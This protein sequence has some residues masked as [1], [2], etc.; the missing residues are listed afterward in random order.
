MSVRKV[1]RVRNR[2]VG[3]FAR[4]CPKRRQGGQYNRTANLI[5]FNNNQGFLE[6]EPMEEDPVEVLQAQLNSLST[7]NREK[8]ALAMGGGD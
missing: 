2:E 7:E 6:T 3:H 1:K 8:L 5:D 4:N